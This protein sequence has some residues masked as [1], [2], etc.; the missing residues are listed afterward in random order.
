MTELDLKIEGMGRRGEGV[1]S[2]DGRTRLRAGHAARRG[3]DGSRATATA[4]RSS[5]SNAPRRTAS[6]PFCGYYGRCGGCQL[7][8]WREEPY[9]AWKASLVAEQLKARGLAA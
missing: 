9:R 8:H 1:A 5:P 6:R 7:Q 3:G 4:C 2:H